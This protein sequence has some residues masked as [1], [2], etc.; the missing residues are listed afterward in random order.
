MK[1]HYKKRHVHFKQNFAV[2]V[3]PN[4]FW[5]F[6]GEYE[7]FNRE[8]L[9]GKTHL[10]LGI[11]LSFLFETKWPI[12][13][14]ISTFINLIKRFHVGKTFCPWSERIFI[15]SWAVHISVSV[16]QAL[17]KNVVSH[18]LKVDQR[19]L[20]RSR[21]DLDP[22]PPEEKYILWKVFV[23]IWLKVFPLKSYLDQEHFKRHLLILVVKLRRRISIRR[24][25]LI[26]TSLVK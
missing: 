17:E 7:P 15:F 26:L 21:E 10:L 6:F 4:G 13:S 22:E 12:G 20:K 24:A 11:F 25:S 14:N 5:H 1:P 16:V 23:R 8:D 19:G 18:S 9:S 3:G 2:G